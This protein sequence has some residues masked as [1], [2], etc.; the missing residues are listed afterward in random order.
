MKTAKYQKGNNTQKEENGKRENTCKEA[1]LETRATSAKR[2][3]N[4][5]KRRRFEICK[6]ATT[7]D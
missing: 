1:M 2:I 4:K 7:T 3:N 5:K 6:T